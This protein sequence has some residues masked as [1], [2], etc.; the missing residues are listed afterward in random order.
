MPSSVLFQAAILLLQQVDREA[1]AF[2]SHWCGM[3][4]VMCLRLC[5]HWGKALLPSG[6]WF[7]Y[8]AISV[9]LDRFYVPFSNDKVLSQ[10]KFTTIYTHT[11]YVLHKPQTKEQA[12]WLYE[13]PT[14][15]SS[16]RT[17]YYLLVKSKF[18][19]IQDPTITELSF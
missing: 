1:R 12:F 11:F 14:Q 4:C 3:A 5:V 7:P 15:P 16:S 10:C 19:D 2:L 17:A 6:F 13:F 9:G 8:Q 18:L